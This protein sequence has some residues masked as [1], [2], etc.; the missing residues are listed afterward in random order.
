MAT[1][2]DLRISIS[3]MDDAEAFELVKQIRFIRRQP[4]PQ[5]AKR[6]AG[7][8]KRSV[9]KK[10]PVSIVSNMTPEQAA[11]LLKQLGG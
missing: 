1:I 11:E 9:K 10:D 8:K 7:S 5:K 3:Q 4:P 6:A 2:E